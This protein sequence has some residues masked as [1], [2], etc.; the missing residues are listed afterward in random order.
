MVHGEPGTG[1]SVVLRLL[2]ERLAQLPDLTVGAI[3]HPQSNLADFYREL[4]E[5][6]AVPL[7]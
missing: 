3:D 2:A 6:F 7:R 4:G 1:K 5:L